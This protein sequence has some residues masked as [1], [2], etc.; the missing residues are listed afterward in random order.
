[1][2]LARSSLFFAHSSFASVSSS[3][4]DL[5]RWRPLYSQRCRRPAA[6]AAAGPSQQQQQHRQHGRRTLSA[7]G[8]NNSDGVA[9]DHRRFPPPPLLLLRPRPPPLTCALPRR[10]SSEMQASSLVTRRWY[11]SRERAPRAF[12]ERERKGE[13]RLKGRLSDL[14]FL[15]STST[16]KPHPLP[17]LSLQLRAH[18]TPVRTSSGLPQPPCRGLRR[19]RRLQAGV[20]GAVLEV[21]KGKREKEER[22]E[23]VSGFFSSCSTSSLIS[24]PCISLSLSLSFSLSLSLSLSLPRPPS[25]TIQQTASRTASPSA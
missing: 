3:T 16:S 19:A 4:D 2:C 9:A 12:G 13:T 22:E 1:M 25:T 23:A 6:P 18:T 8:N 17:L 14:F 20:H 21:S 15:L 5:P 11:F 10:A 7:V 24:S